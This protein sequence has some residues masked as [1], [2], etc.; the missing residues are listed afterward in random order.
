[1]QLKEFYGKYGRLTRR[2]HGLFA[3]VPAH[4]VD[5]HEVAGV[6]SGWT[7]KRLLRRSSGKGSRKQDKGFSASSAASFTTRGCVM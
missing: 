6:S 1:M 4:L 5:T 7:K 2:Y 3:L